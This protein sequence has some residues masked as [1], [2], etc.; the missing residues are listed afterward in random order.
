MDI[1]INGKNYATSTKIES[2]KF[3]Q[4][5]RQL[6]TTGQQSRSD[7]AP[8]PQWAPDDLSSGVG[9]KR[10]KSD[11]PTYHFGSCETIWGVI[12]LPLKVN[13]AGRG[14]NVSATDTFQAYCDHEG[15]VFA[16]LQDSDKC[17]VAKWDTTN[18][19][20]DEVGVIDAADSD[21][22]YDIVSH[23][24]D[25]KLHAI[26][27][28]N[29]TLHTYES[30]DAGATWTVNGDTNLVG[31][32]PAFLVSY[33]DDIYICTWTTATNTINVL[34]ST[35][36]CET[37]ASVCS[38]Y[39]KEGPK[40]II[41][42]EHTDGTV[43]PFVRTWEGTW[44]CKTS[45]VKAYDT[46][47]VGDEA[48]AAGLAVWN[49]DAVIPV[50]KDII[51]R[52]AAGVNTQIGPTSRDGFPAAYL[53]YISAVLPCRYHLLFAVNGGTYQGIYRYD[54]TGIH[55]LYVPTTSSLGAIT[56]IHASGSSGIP[57]LFFSH[58]ANVHKYIEY[59][60]DNPLEQS[61]ATYE[62]E[63]FIDFPVFGGDLAEADGWYYTISLYGEALT[64][65]GE[66]VE[67]FTKHDAADTWTFRGKLNS[68]V[69]SITLDTSGLIAKTIQIHLRLVRG[70]TTTATPVV[71]YFALDF[72]KILKTLVWYTFYI[73][74]NATDREYPDATPSVE[75]IK[76][77]R[78]GNGVVP[79]QY[80]DMTEAILAYAEEIDVWEDNNVVIAKF[81]L[82]EM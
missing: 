37:W 26:N 6:R 36:D 74:C 3:T 17:H 28:D 48:A 25:G 61:S 20:W 30:D 8:F 16:L 9:R 15:G 34:K 5:P 23:A 82:V 75:A 54:G 73:D 19:E 53:G 44:V 47:Q 56:N 52:T 1:R 60:Q 13:Q 12:T 77:L 50:G 29:T 24:G 32:G 46:T 21:G 11:E 63:G 42:M 55:P 80:G 67:V 64:D 10:Y 57:T 43:Y 81:K 31:L 76:E 59:Y 45:P 78:R 7:R 58:A 39:S 65:D 68:S 38:L 18:K 41:M 69:T 35:D 27:D 62:A 14:T 2:H 79:I 22:S 72:Q 33:G 66:E 40:G 49:E 71:R 51:L 70:S 4:W